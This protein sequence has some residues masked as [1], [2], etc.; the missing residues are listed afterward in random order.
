MSTYDRQLLLCVTGAE[1]IRRIE[2]V[3]SD[4]GIQLIVEDSPAALLENPRLASVDSVVVQFDQ[5]G[6]EASLFVEKCRKQSPNTPVIVLLQ[7]FSSSEAFRF[8][9][10]GVFNCLDLLSA[11]DQLADTFHLAYCHV[12][13]SR[14]AC[15]TA[16]IEP[17]RQ[18]LVGRSSSMEQVTRIIRLVAARR[19]TVLISGE[20]GTGKEL[21]ARALHMASDRARKP[22]VA[23]N[24]SAIPENLIEAELFGHVKGAFTG[25]INHRIGRFE[26]AHGQLI[27]RPN[28]FAFC[29]SVKCSGLA[30][31]K[32]LRL[33]CGL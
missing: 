18:H 24:C 29:R 27:C 15:R 4:L 25:A 20:T 6:P 11:E 3:V 33:T 30:P 1:T 17:W 8:A 10:C 5:F 14:V 23:V 12:S 2:K 22:M 19:C 28:S 26:Q 31:T 7:Q 32:P 13:Q 16:A 21:A 9:Q